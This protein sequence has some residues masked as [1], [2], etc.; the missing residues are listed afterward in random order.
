MS[1]APET[2]WRTVD[3]DSPFRIRHFESN[4]LLCEHKVDAGEVPTTEYTRADLVQA[5]I[6]AAVAAP[7]RW[8]TIRG[9]PELSG[10]YLV[11]YKNGRQQVDY[12]NGFCFVD[13]EDRS[14]QHESYAPPGSEP[15]S[16][17]THWMPLPAGPEDKE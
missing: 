5:R 2:I 10:Y 15:L 14:E 7:L 17:I 11:Q 16:K 13:D 8:R 9:G 12:W 1:D 6:D 3:P 4:V